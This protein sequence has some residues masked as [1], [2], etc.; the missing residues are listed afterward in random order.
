MTDNIL[1]IARKLGESIQ[2]SNLYKDYLLREENFHND[3]EAS[4]LQRKI[5]NKNNIYKDL[6]LKRETNRIKDITIEIDDLKKRLNENNNYKDYNIAKVN[7]ENLIKNINNIL[8]YYTGINSG[9]GCS[10]CSKKCG[11]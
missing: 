11:K 10:N 6:V 5:D 3:E 4:R 1:D 8:E 2:G 9:S 7:L